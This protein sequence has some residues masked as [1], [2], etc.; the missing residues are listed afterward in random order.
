MSEELHPFP[1]G[2]NK[3]KSLVN[4]KAPPPTVADIPADDLGKLF[5]TNP[6]WPTPETD[7]IKAQRGSVAST[8]LTKTALDQLAENSEG[9]TA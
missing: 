4:S 9:E 7:A 1:R 6:R 5:Q 2:A 8:P 3:L